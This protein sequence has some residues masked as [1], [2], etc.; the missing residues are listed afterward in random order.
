MSVQ[1]NNGVNVSKRG[2]YE[3]CSEGLG[4]AFERIAYSNH[5]MRLAKQYNCKSILELNASYIAG[6]PGFNS[7]ILAQNGFDVTVAV[8]ERD[9]EDTKHVWELTG[10]KTNIVKIN[11]SFKTSFANNSY[12]FVYNHLAFDQYKN[13]RPLVDEM[14]RI[15]RKLIMNLTLSPY[16]YGYW[17]HLLNH[18]M[19]HKAWDHGYRE[20]ATI[21]AM[22]KI[23]KE[24][25]VNI[26]E[27]G[28]CDI[29]PWMDT[30]DAKMGDSMT[31]LDV[32]P[33]K[34]RSKWVWTS[35]NPECQN[36]K[37]VKMLWSWELALPM[38]FKKYAC[39]HLYIA[40]VKRC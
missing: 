14:Y 24:Y 27:T 22:V 3:I 10:L 29:P 26:I 23:H 40:S 4:G 32:F 6:I 36:N 8:K 25:P 33:H 38:W 12:D 20:M 2:V 13:P 30:I 5:I 11:S 9:Y 35:V 7:C 31:Y 28:A 1:I 37:L 15:S 39:H 16:N 18:K 19:Q 17:I 34:V 21:P